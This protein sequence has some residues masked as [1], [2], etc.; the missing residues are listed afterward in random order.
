MPKPANKAPLP[1]NQIAEAVDT[2]WSEDREPIPALELAA[3]FPAPK[4]DAWRAAV[5]K[6]LKGEDFDKKMVWR[7]E[8]GIPV[9]PLYTRG[10]LADLP[11]S[12]S[13]PGFAPF[14]RGTHPLAGV[15]PTWQVRQDCL[16]AAPEEVNA[17]LRDGIARGQTA[18]GIRLDNAARQGLDGDAPEARDLAGRSGCTLSSINGLRIA[19]QDIDLDKYPVTLRTGAAALPV[20]AMLLALA[21]ERGI[22]R[23][24]LTGSVECDPV[25]ELAKSGTVCV[26]LDVEMRLMADMVA[27]CAQEAPGVRPVI[28]NSHHWHG[29]GATA[30]QEL[31]ATMATAAEYLRALVQRGVAIDT[32]ALGM[33]F[34]FSVSTN[35]LIEIAKL[36]AARALWAK[37]VRAF[38]SKNDDA[39]RMFLH[40]RTST[41]TKTRNDPWNNIVRNAVE[42]FAAAVGG[43]DSMY[44]APFDETLGNADDF[45]MRVARNQ[46]LLLMEEAHL[47]RVVDPAAG[48]YAIES[49]TDAVA[50]EAWKFFQEIEA[51]GGV[52]KA[53]VGGWLQKM[54]GEAGEKRRAAVTKRRQSIVGVSTYPN[55]KER[56]IEKAHLPRESFVDERH[57]RL[58]RLKAVRQNSHVRN[59]LSTIT[60][61]V[62]SNEGN[63]LETAIV[64]V[65]AGATIGEVMRAIAMGSDGDVPRV[66]P[67]RGERA[68]VPF[69]RLRAR[70]DAHAKDHDGA[71]PRAL[72]VPMGPLAMRR[73]RADFSLGFL[74]AGGFDV[75]EAEP[76]ADVAAAAAAVIASDAMLAVVCSDDPG[77]PTIVPELVERVHARRPGFPIYVAGFPKD[78]ID[79]LTKAGAAGFIHIRADVVETLTD[80]FNK[81]GVGLLPA[82]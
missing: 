12:R 11:L 21:D 69:E 78:D 17:A 30:V 28:V 76:A 42:G 60:G 18:L 1:Q 41:Y 14:V 6:E 73:A 58:S 63:L 31:G 43:V 59:L 55:P 74:G 20:L 7:T 10:V 79:A 19:L 5:E 33:V 70:A 65:R 50:A 39:A 26:P 29:A 4:P 81:L 53:L 62:Y 52:T 72:L 23:R 75:V 77:Y 47:G 15:L 64:A 44:V 48:S 80:I 49:L 22:D 34:S 40:A 16:L 8:E 67:V 57:R 37:I 27:Y 36:R 32:A 71:L 82:K 68:S 25:R 46:Q 45:G 38:G 66:E 35:M 2:E 9:Q 56:R 51:R 24:V 61:S 13:L 54:I 3:D